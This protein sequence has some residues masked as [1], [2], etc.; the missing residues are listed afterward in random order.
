MGL[1]F[2]LPKTVIVITNFDELVVSPPP[3]NIPNFFCSLFNILL[4]F[5]SQD[6]LANFLFKAKDKKY[7]FG[8]IPLQYK[9]DSEERNIFFK[10]LFGSDESTK[11]TPSTYVSTEIAILF[12]SSLY[13]GNSL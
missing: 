9:S 13:L 4:I 8:L 6:T 11:W 3:R 2:A 7:D 12:I 1:F 5:L 10:N